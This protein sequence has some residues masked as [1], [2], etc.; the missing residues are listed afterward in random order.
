MAFDKTEYI[1]FNGA[2]VPWDQATVHVTTHALHYG[3]SVFEGIRAYEIKGQPNIFCLDAHVKRMFN[4]CK[5]Y[6]MEIGYTP[7]TI[8]Q[9]ICDTIKANQV[10]ECYIRPLV[11]YGSGGFSLDPRQLP[12]HVSIILIKMG[13]YL[14]PEAIEQGVDVGVSSW[15][16][17]APG[18]FPA[19]AK[20]G[21]Q[22]IN[23]QFIA[24]ES[25]DHGYTEGIALDI[26][27]FVSEGSGE[28][29][30]VVR[31]G[32]IYTPP[33]YASILQGVT[34]ACVIALARDLGYVVKE[35]MLPREMLYM[36][37]EVFFT[38]TAAEV[39]PIR[40]IDR[41]TIGNGRRGPVT[42]RIQAAFFGILAGEMQ[43]R[44]GWLTPVAL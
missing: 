24:M 8:K 12:V 7:E 9:A 29:I 32:V 28:N 20:I 36:A 11:F 19:V 41:V 26:N 43:D 44:Y 33:L 35:E 18:T 6:R 5:V 37:D 10:Q 27:N 16:R 31:D 17:M 13:R 14:G 21:G 23:S 30:F 38:G 2:L 25:T 39:T 3:S 22:Y 40:S 15:R 1:W 4:S 34:R 42:E